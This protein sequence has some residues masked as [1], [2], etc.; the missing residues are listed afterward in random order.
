[1]KHN[2]DKVFAPKEER[3]TAPITMNFTP[4]TEGKYKHI[5]DVVPDKRKAIAQ[6]RDAAEREINELYEKC[7]HM[8][9]AG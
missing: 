1:M 7:K 4:S 2:L 5:V 9:R 6:I 3:L 8:E